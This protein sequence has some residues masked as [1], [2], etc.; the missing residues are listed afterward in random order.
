MR[1]LL[2]YFGLF[3]CLDTE[4]VIAGVLILVAVCF[5]PD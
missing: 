1:W 3:L 2:V 4:D 5:M